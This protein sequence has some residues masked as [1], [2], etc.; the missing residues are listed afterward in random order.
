VNEGNDSGTV[1]VAF[2]IGTAAGGTA[3]HVTAL[4]AGC[5]RAGMTVTVL[6]PE[7]ARQRFT[8]GVPGVAPRAGTAGVPGV[9][10]RPSTAPVS[11]VP[12]RIGERPRPVGDA[13]S[14]AGLRRGLRI[15]RPD[16]VHAHGVRAGAFAAVA[17]Q[18]CSGAEPALVVT[19]HNAPPVGTAGRLVYAVLERI[20]AR[21]ADV[22]LC[23]SPDLVTRARRI[24][25]RDVRQFD[26]P[27]PAAKVP[28]A[29]A[30][31]QAAA[32]IGANGRPVVLAV[33]RLAPQKGFDVLVAAAARWRDRVPAPRTAIAGS[34]PLERDLTAQA[35]RTG[36][37][38][39][40]LG[41]RDDVTALLAVADVFV[42]PSRWEARALV[43]QEALRAGRPVVATDTGGTS[44]LVG[45]DGALLVPPNDE[46]ALARAV[47]EVLADPALA[48][49]LGRA[50]LVRAASLPTEDDALRTACSLYSSLTATRSSLQ[51]DESG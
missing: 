4:A 49:G 48:A 27:A 21:R 10:P 32:D 45:E 17:I 38:V 34:G 31:A 37:D 43:L 25:A 40:L 6:G 51:S 22:V 39:V 14:I 2:L 41:E 15:I 20:C 3:G 1:R 26:V 12:V 33:G 35:S 11:F 36:A 16:V 19:M 28:S 50:G 46:R 8:A 9:A 5:S 13:V 7:Q 18:F 29:A 24:G 42:L 44:A 30:L 23:A 47:L